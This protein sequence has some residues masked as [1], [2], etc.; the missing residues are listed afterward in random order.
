VPNTPPRKGNKLH[1]PAKTND[2][3][4]I[5]RK[6]AGVIQLDKTFWHKDANA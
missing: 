5:D 2:K 1:L 6:N 3:V 4:M